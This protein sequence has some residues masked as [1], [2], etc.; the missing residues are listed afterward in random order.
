[1]IRQSYYFGAVICGAGGVFFA[2]YFMSQNLDVDEYGYFSLIISVIGGISSIIL[3][4]QATS[5]SVVIFSDEKAA[6]GNIKQEYIKSLSIIFISFLIVCLL[7]FI[8]WK[9]LYYQNVSLTFLTLI[10]TV[11]LAI[12]LQLFFISLVQCLDYYRIYF[13]ASLIGGAVLIAFASQS[14]NSQEYFRGIFL[15]SFLIAILVI[16][17]SSKLIF[18]KEKCNSE[19]IFSYKDLVLLGY[20]AIPGMLITAANGFFDKYLLS[21]F[22]TLEVVGIYSLGFMV[23]VGIG[24]LLVSGILR[25]NSIHFMRHLQQNEIIKAQKILFNSELILCFFSAIAA[26]LFYTIGEFLVL[27]VFGSKYSES[28]SIMLPLFLAV[29]IEGMVFFLGQAL[30]QKKKLFLLVLNNLGILLFMIFGNYILIPII[31]IEAP[32]IIMF[33]AQILTIFIVY[34]QVKKIADWV[35]FPWYILS[36]TIIIFS[37]NQFFWMPL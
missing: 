33:I 23:S 18:N 14:F 10:L 9:L 27:I 13:W 26:V 19:I 1:M 36:T 11:S 5:L 6:H 32:I 8:L 15:A 28:Y 37:F 29:M 4:G 21:K 22:M 2:N 31:C 25:A 30:I 7:S 24:R 16:F 34:H 12:S 3:F 17:S 35:N 20:V